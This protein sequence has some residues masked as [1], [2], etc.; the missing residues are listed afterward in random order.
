MRYA[1][2]VPNFE[3]YS[4]VRTVAGLAADAEAAGW[5]GFFV[6]D[7]LAFVKAWK[8]RV[9]DPWMLLTG[10]ALA[11]ERLRLGPMVTPV[12]R[13]RPWKLARETVTLD[14]LSG[15]RLILGVGLGEPPEDEYGSFGEP[16]DPVVRAAM[17]DE[18]LEVLTRLWSGETVSF[19]G[20]HYRVE[21]VAFQ[22]TPVQQPRIP[23]WVAGAW[24]RRGPLRRAAR[25]DGSCPLKVDAGGELVVLE[26]GD[27]RELRAVVDRHREDPA[28]PFDVM[29]GGAT[30]EDPAA[31]RAMLETLAEA[32]V[33]WWQE[34][35][36]PRQTDLEAFRRRVRKGPPGA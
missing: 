9:A 12:P 27:V 10:V 29:L 26:P 33:T 22:P 6:W 32:G 30:P 3:D 5:D 17:L 13:R 18:G 36:D 21:E 34:S 15:G 2:N 1:V 23:I 28:A 4:D 24:P 31:A 25:F 19:E 11:T 7:H 20:R 35:V 8:L 14:R 16:T